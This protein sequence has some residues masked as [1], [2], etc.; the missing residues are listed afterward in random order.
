M[1][2]KIPNQTIGVF[3]SIYILYINIKGSDMCHCLIFNF[4]SLHTPTTQ[5][6]GIGNIITLNIHIHHMPTILLVELR[7]MIYD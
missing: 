5:K 4:Q 3:S 2:W 7:P 1:S 6:I